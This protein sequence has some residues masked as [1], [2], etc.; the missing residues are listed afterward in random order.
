[1]RRAYEPSGKVL[2]EEK[3][4]FPFWL[5]ILMV[6]ITVLIIAGMGVMTIAVPEEKDE[7][8]LGL[9]IAL[10]VQ[11]GVIIL[12]QKLELEKIVTTKGLYYRWTPWHK[13]YRLIETGSIKK[14]EIRK[15]PQLHYGFSWFPRYGTIHNA[16]MGEG[17]QLYLM[18]GNKIYFSTLET[19]F[20]CRALQK[21]NFIES[22]THGE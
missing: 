21:F 16:C 2:F 5:T 14:V 18:N 4:K 7:A 19:V 6:G 8:I 11:T 13:K 20:F 22:K 12:F 1:M 17:V 15:V 10:P 3:Q 9:A